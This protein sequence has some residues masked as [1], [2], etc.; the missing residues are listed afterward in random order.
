MH[1]AEPVDAIP[2]TCSKTGNPI[3]GKKDN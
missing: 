3:N 1:M 2:A